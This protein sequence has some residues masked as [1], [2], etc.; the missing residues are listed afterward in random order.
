MRFSVII[1]FYCAH[2]TIARCLDSLLVQS[3]SEDLE[4]FCI[5]DKTPDPTHAII[6]EYARKHPGVVQLHLRDGR[7]QGGA[8]N[9]GLSLAR[10]EYIMFVDADDYVE[11]N[12]LTACANALCEHNADFVCA[13]FDRVAVS[14]EKYSAEQT[15]PEVTLVDITSENVSRLAFIYTASWGKLFRRETIGD[16]RFPENPTAAYEDL[17]FSLS[18]CPQIR[19]YVLLPGVLYHYIVYGESTMTKAAQTLER[20]RVFRKDMIALRQS[21]LSCSLPSPYLDMLDTA[22]FIHVGIADA[23]RMAENPSVPLRD[24]CAKARDF[25]QA[26]FPGWRRIPLRPYGR[27]TLRCT[28]VWFA[29]YLYCLGLFWLFIRLYNYMIKTLHVDIKW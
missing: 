27:F 16:L 14:G 23:H 22:A 6:E 29:K 26:H 11:P 5:G 4:I 24:F 1:P 19:R 18:L 9:L 13:G 15:V 7:E 21:F 8:R 12:I 25:L 3:V 2:N 17:I 10:G 20:T 28:A